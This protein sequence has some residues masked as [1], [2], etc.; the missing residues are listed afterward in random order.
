LAFPAPLWLGA[1]EAGPSR[2]LR[3]A[4]K[5]GPTQAGR[6]GE[7]GTAAGRPQVM[8]SRRP[9][10]GRLEAGGLRE[11]AAQVG[12]LGGGRRRK[13]GRLGGTPPGPAP[14]GPRRR[15]RRSRR[16]CHGSTPRSD[17]GRAPKSAPG[18]GSRIGGTARGPEGSGAGGTVPR[19]GTASP[20]GPGELGAN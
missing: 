14:P 15:A 16:R 18:V 4:R 17:G 19:S 6:A 13:G 5:A 12:G 8:Q 11:A 10:E 7:S 9:G 3:T 20:G 2:R 1:G